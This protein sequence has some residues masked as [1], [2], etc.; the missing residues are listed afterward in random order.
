MWVRGQDQS[1]KGHAD[2]VRGLYREGGRTPSQGKGNKERGCGVKHPLN[3]GSHNYSQLVRTGLFS[4]TGFLYQDIESAD[5]CHNKLL[6]R[7]GF[8]LSTCQS[9]SANK[10]KVNFLCVTF[11]LFL[12][13]LSGEKT[14]PCTAGGRCEVQLQVS[15]IVCGCCEP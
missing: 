7:R 3:R 14:G 12:I 6:S 2:Q 13:G 15:R 4:I 8:T 1:Q 11:L 5:C 9:S 10:G